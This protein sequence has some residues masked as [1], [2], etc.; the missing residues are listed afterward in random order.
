MRSGVMAA[1]IMAAEI[2]RII[3]SLLWLAELSSQRCPSSAAPGRHGPPPFPDQSGGAARD[4]CLTHEDNANDLRCVVVTLTWIREAPTAPGVVGNT[5]LVVSSGAFQF[6]QVFPTLRMR[7]TRRVRTV[8][9]R[10]DS[11]CF[12][13]NPYRFGGSAGQGFP[14]A[15]KPCAKRSR[16][17]PS[18]KN[19]S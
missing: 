10:S 8:L 15:E 13:A 9:K 17:E 14:E 6:L 3:L 5:D 1:S 4:R 12:C 11:D 18:A 7:V 16:T 2:N 19:R